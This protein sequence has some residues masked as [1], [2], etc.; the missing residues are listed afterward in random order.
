MMMFVLVLQLLVGQILLSTVDAVP[1]GWSEASAAAS[2]VHVATAA[3]HLAIVVIHW[4]RSLVRVPT[5]HAATIGNVAESAGQLVSWPAKVHV[6]LGFAVPVAGTLVLVGTLPATRPSSA[7]V[8]GVST[9]VI[10]VFPLLRRWALI[11]VLPVGTIFVVDPAVRFLPAWLVLPVPGRSLLV[12]FLIVRRSVAV[13]RWPVMIST[14]PRASIFRRRSPAIEVPRWFTITAPVSLDVVTSRRRII[15]VFV[16]AVIVST[17]A[18]SLVPRAVFTV[19]VTANRP[20]RGRRWRM[21]LVWTV[22]GP[23][24][25]HDRL[26]GRRIF[27]LTRSAAPVMMLVT[28]VRSFPWK[29]ITRCTRGVRR[30]TPVMIV[31]SWGSGRG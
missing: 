10:V 25:T 20:C 1:V 19:V 16:T 3:V 17:S 8:V 14:V 23:R 6:F 31:L 7:V 11:A 28:I 21:P 26:L 13:L 18:I 30:T 27:S 4:G 2:P 24:S 12:R 22:P 29:S 15:R 5:E 9:G